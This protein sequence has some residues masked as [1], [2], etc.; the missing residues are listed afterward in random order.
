MIWTT[1]Q[2][3]LT[4]IV[5]RMPACPCMLQFGSAVVPCLSFLFSPCDWIGS[6]CPC[7]PCFRFAIGI[8]IVFSRL[9][10]ASFTAVLDSLCREVCFARSA[11]VCRKFAKHLQALCF[12]ALNCWF[13]LSV[14]QVSGESPRCDK[15]LVKSCS[16]RCS[17][18]VCSCVSPTHSE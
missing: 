8:W 7:R 13:L 5:Q 2:Y 14:S 3:H 18:F 10:H 6:R 15:A 4:H 16:C 17:F 11:C 9:G 12:I 1:N